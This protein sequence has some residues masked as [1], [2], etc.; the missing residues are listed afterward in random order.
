MKDFG[1]KFLMSFLRSL[2]ISAVLLL[3]VTAATA[4]TYTN[5]YAY[6]GT[7]NNT[8]GITWPSVMSQGQDGDLYSTIQTN[9]SYQY[10]S[11]YKM[12]TSGGYTLLYS[13]CGEGSPCASTGA[14]PT[15]GVTLGWDGN[16]WGTTYNGGKDGAGT[17]FKMTPAGDLTSLYSF[18]NG[19][20][21]S[22]PTYTLL[23]GQ[24]G[25]MYG[26]SEAQ[27]EGQY[28]SFF[29]LTTKGKISAY[30]FDYTD[31]SSPNLPVQGTDLNFYGTTQGGGN[32]ACAC[33]VIYK[34]TAAGKITVLHNFSGYVSSTQ[35]DGARPIGIL[36]EGADGNFYG[37]TYQGGEYNAGT[38]F[39]IAP[40]GTYTLLH[41]FSF[42]A[43]TYDG[44]LPIAGLT[45]GTDGNF[46]GTTAYG[47]TQNGGA[48]FEITPAGKETVLYNFC[49]V[50]CYDGFI[51]TT[52]M[53]L[54]TDG[55]FYGNTAGNSNGGSV[56]YSFKTKLKPFVKLVTWSGKDGAS[57]E[58]LGQ[59]FTG[60]TAVSFNGIAAKFDNVS[61]TY[62]TATVPTGA[63]TGP[64]TVTTFSSSL[65]SDRNFLVTPQIASFAPTSGVVGTSVTITGVS[66]T[67]T[68][69]VTIGTKPASFAVDSDTQITATVPAGAKTGTTITVTTAGGAA[70]SKAKFTVVPEVTSFTP[71]SGPTGT[72]VTITGNSFTGTTKVTFGGVAAT[73]YKAKS[74]TTVDALVPAGAVTGPI[75]VTTA[76]GTGTSTTKFTVTQ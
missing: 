33:G 73:S 26:V 63:L 46:Y 13:F 41:S 52:P 67:Q 71:T 36:V 76:G 30:P 8:S 59:G 74:D 45:L 12:S 4:Q 20:D 55:I 5:L 3:A 58:I 64:V 61:D 35:Y 9:G 6:P 57:A 14:N 42:Q 10:G 56:F 16:L 54:H 47:G 17:A 23:Q 50:S 28:G 22:A 19:K 24:D 65:K 18:T 1:T 68:T 21:D 60:T 25:N 69:A 66:L 51:P 48:I 2:S 7:D 34:A 53:V 44:Q 37:T 62:M 72:S 29:K 31:G 11:V 70:T 43:P 49:V 38:V 40:S 27:Y 39:K 32:A 15:G 75:A